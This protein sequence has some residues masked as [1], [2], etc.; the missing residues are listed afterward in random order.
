MI[1]HASVRLLTQALENLYSISFHHLFL[2]ASFT[3]VV[4]GQCFLLNARLGGV[5]DLEGDLDS[6]QV[7]LQL[8]YLTAHVV[9][10][11]HI[12]S[13]PAAHWLP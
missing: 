8:F 10:T 13:V 1:S 6:Q 11:L 7:S 3:C 4:A 2:M 12:F 9:G 5:G